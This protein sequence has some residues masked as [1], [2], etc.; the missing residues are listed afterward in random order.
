MGA[1]TRRNVIVSERAPEE[2]LVALTR[3]EDYDLVVLGSNLR[4]LSGRGFFG[5]RVEYVLQNAACPVVVLAS[6]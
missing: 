6:S 1:E 2:E 4:P 5:Y 3:R